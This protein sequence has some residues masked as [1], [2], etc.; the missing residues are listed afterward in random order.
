MTLTLIYFYTSALEIFALTWVAGDDSHPILSH[1][2]KL[3][4][5][6][7]PRTDWMGPLSQ[8]LDGDMVYFQLGRTIRLWNWSEDTQCQLYDGSRDSVRRHVLTF[9]CPSNTTLTCRK[10]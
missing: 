7:N 10:K 3:Q 5:M 9:T 6:T 8:T 2:A 4:V 1:L